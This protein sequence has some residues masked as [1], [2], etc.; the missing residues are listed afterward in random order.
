[1]GNKAESWAAWETTKATTFSSNQNKNK[2]FYEEKGEKKCLKVKAQ[3]VTKMDCFFL[4]VLPPSGK[5]K[6]VQQ[7]TL[8]EREG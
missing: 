4:L 5:P 1:V 7:R 2:T 6:I 3:G 8:S